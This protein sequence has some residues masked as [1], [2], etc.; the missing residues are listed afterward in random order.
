MALALNRATAILFPFS[1]TRIWNFQ[2]TTIIIILI[3]ILPFIIN[4]ESY[5][6]FWDL[7]HGNATKYD[8]Y[9]NALLARCL[10]TSIISG[11]LV[12]LSTILSVFFTKS[13]AIPKSLQH[14][15]RRLIIQ[16]IVSSMLIFS[17]Y[18]FYYLAIYLPTIPN[19]FVDFH[20]RWAFFTAGDAFYMFQHFASIGII[21]IVSP[22]FRICFVRF[23]SWSIIDLE[24]I[25]PRVAVK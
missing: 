6:D 2:R 18:G 23:I 24:Y 20:N 13:V 10:L 11:I 7:L 5:K 19:G 15:E 12:I 22:P 8:S 4:I 3:T 1:Y 25:N 17:Q 9:K 14:V 16:S 21:L